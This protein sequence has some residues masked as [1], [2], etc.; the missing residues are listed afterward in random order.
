LSSFKQLLEFGSQ[1][2]R[3]MNTQYM[4]NSLSTQY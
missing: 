3:L 2:L 4:C 1:Q